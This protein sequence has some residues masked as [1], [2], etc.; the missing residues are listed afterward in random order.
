VRGR[1]GSGL[2]GGPEGRRE[3]T[4]S[5][6]E[7][8][9]AAPHTC[10]AA[11]T[12]LRAC[13]KAHPKDR[14]MVFSGGLT[15]GLAAP[16]DVGMRTARNG[17]LRRR[18]CGVTCDG[19]CGGLRRADAPT[20][21]MGGRPD[22]GGGAE[23]QRGGVPR[24]AAGLRVP[25]RRGVCGGARRGPPGGPPGPPLEPVEHFGDGARRS[26][27]ETSTRPFDV[28]QVVRVVSP[29]RSPAAARHLVRTREPI[30]VCSAGTARSPAVVHPSTEY[31]RLPCAR[32]PTLHP[33][34]AGTPCTAPG[35]RGR[36]APPDSARV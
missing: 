29:I 16:C 6:L 23:R 28:R 1:R 30:S 19:S 31:P 34:P 35:A 2:K 18:A 26:G 21:R 7:A 13:L 17:C 36:S 12:A 32:S 20:R 27:V 24:R 4:R 9:G 33:E 25:V 5:A 22:A 10:G 14:V 3:A 11:E 15:T 8:G